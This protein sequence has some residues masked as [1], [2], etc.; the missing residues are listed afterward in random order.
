MDKLQKWKEK[1]DGLKYDQTDIIYECMDELKN[2]NIDCF[3]SDFNIGGQ[4]IILPYG[5]I[6]LDSCDPFI[7]KEIYKNIL[8]QLFINYFFYKT[9]D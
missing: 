2:D 4:G 9:A 5:V 3:V 8:C 7:K 1:F 6:K